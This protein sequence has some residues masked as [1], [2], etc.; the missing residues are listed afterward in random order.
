MHRTRPVIALLAFCLCASLASGADE[1]LKSN[2]ADLAPSDGAS[3]ALTARGKDVR[4]ATITIRPLLEGHV[5]LAMTFEPVKTDRGR[6]WRIAF[7]GDEPDGVLTAS[8]VK[9]DILRIDPASDDITFEF[10]APIAHAIL[11]SRHTDDWIVDPSAW[12][13]RDELHLPSTHLVTALLDGGQHVLVVAWGSDRPAASFLLDGPKDKRSASGIRIRTGGAPIFVRVLSQ[14]D[15]WHSET[16]PEKAVGQRRELGWSPP[17]EA[18]WKTQLVEDGVP[19]AYPFRTFKGSFGKIYRPRYFNAEYPCYIVDGVATVRLHKKLAAD[20]TLLCYATE[21]HAL[22]PWAVLASCVTDDERKAIEQL[23]AVRRVHDL[24]RSGNAFLMQAACV[25]RDQIRETVYKTGSQPREAQFLATYAEDR[26]ENAC[27]AELAHRRYERYIETLR[28]IADRWADGLPDKPGGEAFL[29]TLRKDI[30]R[31]ASV[32]DSGMKG[33]SAAE[34]LAQT[35]RLFRRMVELAREPG[36]EV[37]AEQR[38]VLDRLNASLSR[39]EGLGR[40]FGTEV[41]R[42]HRSAARRAAAH[43]GLR[44]Y[45]DRL[46]Q[47]ALDLLKL[48]R[49]ES[50]FRPDAVRADG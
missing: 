48:R 27:V 47:S 23:S 19:T 12:P 8:F 36:E 50:V 34:R 16:L 14:A 33:H 28:S 31:M 1:L 39:Y 43:P 46:R 15:I 37:Y 45:A 18:D 17:F 5:G 21:G 6:A 11:P 49:W 38:H 25:G 42:L 32:Y 29:E 40:R 26:R 4:P 24:C 9:D 22:T 13:D 10:A 2:S 44:P 7:G 41:R 35:E 20:R 3:L 30:D